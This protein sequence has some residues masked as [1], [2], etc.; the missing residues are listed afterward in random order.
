MVYLGCKEVKHI[1]I[2]SLVRNQLSEVD[3]D[4]TNY[5]EWL[6]IISDS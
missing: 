4:N 5:M 3:F 1:Q 6:F 2:Y